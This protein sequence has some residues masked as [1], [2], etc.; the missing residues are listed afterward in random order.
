MNP[1]AKYSILAWALSIGCACA[2]GLVPYGLECEARLDPVGIDARQPRL[3]WKL[4]GDQQNQKQ[5]AYQLEVAT[6][7]ERLAA[8]T[9]D[10][11]DS[12]R[13][14]SE[15][16]AWIP[17]GGAPLTSFRHYWWRVRVW[18]GLGAE[19]AW[20]QPAEWTTALINPGLRKGSW[21]ASPD[22]SLRSGPLPVF[23]KEFTIE[24]P[25][26]Q[27]LAM[28]SGAGFHELRVNGSKVGD[29]VLAPAWTTSGP[30]CFT[31]PSMSPCS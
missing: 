22:T 5:G 10:A 12:G 4:R 13:V 11:W 23:R 2:S 17:Y 28:V 30:P 20:S 27:A 14:T 21:I 16:I 9:P 7:A 19:S 31:R 6:S 15:Q 18:D 1:T 24:K 26:R 29:H 8:G 25:V 3:G